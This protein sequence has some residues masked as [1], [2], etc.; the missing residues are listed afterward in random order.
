[1]CE[2]RKVE[3]NAEKS[4]DSLTYGN[5]GNQIIYINDAPNSPSQNNGFD[6]RCE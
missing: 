5:V 3:L 4:I 1:M 2:A 6:V